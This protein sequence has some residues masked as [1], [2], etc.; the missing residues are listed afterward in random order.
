MSPLMGTPRRRRAYALGHDTVSWWWSCQQTTTRTKKTYRPCQIATPFPTILAKTSPRPHHM[1]S[2]SVVVLTGTYC[3]YFTKLSHT[4]PSF[5]VSLT[6]PFPGML[7]HSMKRSSPP[8][9]VHASPVQVPG[10][11]TLAATSLSYSSGPSTLLSISQVTTIRA[12]AGC[13]CCGGGPPP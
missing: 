10:T 2:I 6:A 8:V 5:P 12:K 7:V 11:A 9:G 3:F 4:S 13:C 1:I